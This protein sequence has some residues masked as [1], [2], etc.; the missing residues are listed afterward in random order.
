MSI[1]NINQKAKEYIDKNIEFVNKAIETYLDKGDDYN[2]KEAS[3]YAIF[4][5][6]HRYRSIICLEL[7]E[8]LG[9]YKSN[10]IESAV[11]IEFIHHASMTCDDLPCMDNSSMRKGKEAV[12][13]KYGEA[14]AILSGLH[15]WNK[16]IQLIN[17][18]AVKHLDKTRDI[19]EINSLMYETIV[20]M[21]EGQELDLREGKTKE[22]LLESITKKNV[23]FNLAC[24][25]PCYLLR[26]KEHLESLNEIGRELSVGYQLYDD[27]RDVEED[28]NSNKNNA[29]Y[30]FGKEKVLERIEEIKKTTIENMRKIRKD[31]ELEGIINIMLHDK[32][33]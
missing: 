12:Y 5:D 23:L 30:V 27:L 32:N 22:K 6:G 4:P 3:N 8:M 10:C 7:Y 20:E 2:L 18:N 31:S 1:L 13:K 28:P 15:S 19:N 24:V 33:E 21:L 26:K 17:N 29:V 11:G 25:L 9:G 16:G 14:N